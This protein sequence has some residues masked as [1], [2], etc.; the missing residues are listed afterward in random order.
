MRCP[1]C[2]KR[3]QSIFRTRCLGCRHPLARV[4]VEAGIPYGSAGTL[5]GFMKKLK[6]NTAAKA[7]A[8][9]AFIH[10]VLM[11][12]LKIGKDWTLV[13]RSDKYQWLR[14]GGWVPVPRRKPCSVR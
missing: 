3:L 14:R 8:M 5:V 2:D 13:L 12:N 7:E 6:G 1:E 11:E 4:M 10:P 9:L